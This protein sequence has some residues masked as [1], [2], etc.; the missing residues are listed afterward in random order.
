MRAGHVL[1]LIAVFSLSLVLLPSVASEDNLVSEELVQES[2]PTSTDLIQIKCA[3][4]S[5][6]NCLQESTECQ[7]FSPAYCSSSEHS[8]SYSTQDHVVQPGSDVVT[9]LHKVVN[10]VSVPTATIVK[11]VTDIVHTPAPPVVHDV[12]TYKVK[13]AHYDLIKEVVP[14]KPGPFIKIVKYRSP[15][16]PGPVKV[17]YV[18]K[19]VPVPVPAP[20][21]AHKV[22]CGIDVKSCFAHRSKDYAQLELQKPID[23][24]RGSYLTMCTAEVAVKR[25]A[26]EKKKGAEKQNKE[27]CVKRERDI[28][29]SE[30]KLKLAT[31][32]EKA[33]KT[34]NESKAKYLEKKVKSVEEA[35]AKTLGVSKEKVA[36]SQEKADEREDELYKKECSAKE[37][38][39]KSVREGKQKMSVVY[40]RETVA[41]KPAP[42]PTPVPTKIVTKT[43]T[44]TPA[45]Q[46]APVSKTTIYVPAPVKAAEKPIVD[47][48]NEVVT[49]SNERLKKNDARSSEIVTKQD[50]SSIE[51]VTKE[52]DTKKRSWTTSELAKKAKVKKEASC[53]ER[54]SKESKKKAEIE[55]KL[56]VE[57]VRKE[58]AKK[59]L[60]SKNLKKPVRKPCKPESSVEAYVKSCKDHTERFAKSEAASEQ[61]LKEVKVKARSDL[62]AAACDFSRHI[63]QEI[64]KAST[65]RE[66]K[67]VSMVNEHTKA[68]EVALKNIDK[69]TA[70]EAAKERYNICEQAAG[71][72]KYFAKTFVFT[73]TG[74]AMT[75]L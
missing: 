17:V 15:A 58:L 21:P 36:K 44:Y 28:K 27:L 38:A 23:H 12:L 53:K 47:T 33:S 63:C 46:P 67:M 55:Q 49:K 70:A 74:N 61:K 34:V 71:D 37:G 64:Y 1:A 6:Y 52:S 43:E 57:K 29:Y 7:D 26:A 14:A 22:K 31:Q 45:P 32:K 20:A 4:G 9:E 69:E 40:V 56:A 59:E 5:V 35:T 75:L 30:K 65:L 41:P 2:T 50:M 68:L 13:R 3:D 60:S 72:M 62:E 51:I 19:P 73:K 8:Y 48:D 66:D 10:Q 39:Y 18:P 42:L 11:H 54:E 24:F 25:A 16:P